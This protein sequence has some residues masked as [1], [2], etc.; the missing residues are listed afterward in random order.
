M[1]RGCSKSWSS[2]VQ[3]CLV[4]QQCLLGESQPPWLVPTCGSP[5]W[6]MWLLWLPIS[7]RMPRLHGRTPDRADHM[8]PCGVAEF[9][10]TALRA[11]PSQIMA[12]HVKCKRMFSCG[13][14]GCMRSKPPWGSSRKRAAVSW[15]SCVPAWAWLSEVGALS[16]GTVLAFWGGGVLGSGAAGCCHLCLG[17]V[18]FGSWR[19]WLLCCLAQP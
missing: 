2:R 13:P 17:G 3:Q 10:A 5:S 18:A 15:A 6:S 9:G 14:M 4:G 12:F 8:W 7:S 11:A 19:V 16:A 1:L